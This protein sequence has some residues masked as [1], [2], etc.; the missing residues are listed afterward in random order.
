MVT[1]PTSIVASLHQRKTGASFALTPVKLGVERHLYQGL[2]LDQTLAPDII[3]A[4]Q[5]LI[6]ANARIGV[7]KATYFP[8]VSLTGGFGTASTESNLLFNGDSKTWQIGADVFGPIF[9]F[10]AIEGQVMTSEAVQREALNNYRQSIITAFREVEDALVATTK[11]RERQEIQGRRTRALQTYSRLARNQYDAGTTGYLQVLDANRSLFVSQ[12]DYV[13]TQTL[14]LTN[15]I[16]VYRALG[17]GWV[18][19]ADQISQAAEPDT[20][21]TQLN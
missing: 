11:G 20:D 14:V 4:E 5:A 21:S 10:G 1:F 16:N 2:P 13:Q 8:R 3:Q 17:G 18:D 9:T 12:L 19:E 15:L 7:A 6:A